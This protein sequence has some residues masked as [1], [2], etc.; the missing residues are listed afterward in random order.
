M[1]GVTYLTERPDFPWI[2]REDLI[3]LPDGDWLKL[4]SRLT[5]EGW[6]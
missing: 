2:R 6:V 4:S 3:V 1:Q 5:Y